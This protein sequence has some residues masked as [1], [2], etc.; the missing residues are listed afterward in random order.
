MPTQ[1]KL[2]DEF[3]VE[4]GTV[5]QALRILQSEHLLVNVSRGAQRPSPTIWPGL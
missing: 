4:R 3:G 1:G 5:R 2:A